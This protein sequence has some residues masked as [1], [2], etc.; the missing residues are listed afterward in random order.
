ML[1]EMAKIQNGHLRGEWKTNGEF[2]SVVDNLYSTHKQTGG[3][4]GG[5][6]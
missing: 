4:V 6:K 2:S 1:R 5:G 3:W